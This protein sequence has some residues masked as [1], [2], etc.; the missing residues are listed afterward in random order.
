[1]NKRILLGLACAS[2]LTGTGCTFP[3]SSPTIPSTQA[4]QLQRADTGR[5]VGVRDVMIEGR[6]THLGQYGGAVLG[7]AA[8]IPSNGVVNSRGRALGVAGASVAGAVVGEAAEEYLTRK[9]AQE[10]TIEM[11]DGSSVVVVQESP[12]NYEVGDLVQVIHGGASARVVLAT[13]I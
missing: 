5:I 6:R 12:P 9:K 4:N 11:R 3:S 13:N 7:G 2:L 1:M 10:I 8:A